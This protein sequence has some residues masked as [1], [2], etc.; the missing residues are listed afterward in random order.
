MR[1]VVRRTV[2]RSRRRQVL[3]NGNVEPPLW[4]SFTDPDH[5][6]RWAWSTHHLTAQRV[7]ALHQQQPDL[8]IVRLRSLRA[9]RSWLSGPL[10]RA[11]ARQ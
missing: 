6:V 7:I 4:K 8:T 9:A 2:R 3:W 11:A 10:Q 5:I 1:Q